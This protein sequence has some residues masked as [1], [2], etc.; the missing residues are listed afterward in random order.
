MDITNED[1][2]NIMG[3]DLIFSALSNGDI[4]MLKQ[5]NFIYMYIATVTC[6]DSGETVVYYMM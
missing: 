1:I 4:Y 2:N 6:I 3:R 5:F